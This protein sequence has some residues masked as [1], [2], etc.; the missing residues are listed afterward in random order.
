MNSGEQIAALQLTVEKMVRASG[1][2]DGFDA[3]RWLEDWLSQRVPA[4]GNRRP[5]D[6][7]TER[8]GF[9]RVQVILL[10]MQSGAYS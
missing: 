3:R 2:P 8:D 7:L 5:A 9:E 6:L 10:R 4:L 1:R